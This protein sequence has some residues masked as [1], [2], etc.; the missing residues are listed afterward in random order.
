M[1]EVIEP[2]VSQAESLLNMFIQTYAIKARPDS[3]LKALYWF[4]TYETHQA[5]THC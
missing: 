5:A 2:V 1:V 4:S 3:V